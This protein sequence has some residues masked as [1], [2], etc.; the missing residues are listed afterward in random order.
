MMLKYHCP[1]AMKARGSPYQLCGLTAKG[2][3][4]ASMAE[5]VKHLC[6]CQYFCPETQSWELKRESLNCPKRQNGR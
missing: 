3:E 1:N 4:T 5:L 6:A 2:M